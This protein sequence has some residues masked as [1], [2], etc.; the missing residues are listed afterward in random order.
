[1]RLAEAVWQAEIV[2]RSLQDGQVLQATAPSRESH[3]IRWSF[4]AAQKMLA[5][6]FHVKLQPSQHASY[7]D[8]C[9]AHKARGQY[10][11]LRQT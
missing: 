4:T 3:S 7:C 9:A 5:Q 6:F 8:G 2:M 10:L 1:M 11:N